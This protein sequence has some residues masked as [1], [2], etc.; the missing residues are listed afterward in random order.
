MTRAPALMVALAL[1]VRDPAPQ[2]PK[3]EQPH[4]YSIPLIDLAAE[5]GRRVV[6]DR[7][8]GWYRVRLMDNKHRRDCAYPG[9]VIQADG[10][11]VTTTYGHWSEGESPYVVSVR[12]KLAELDASAEGLGG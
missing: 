1:L 9:V 7:E 5:T 12:L 2:E 8:A 3:G 4:G 10:T 6:V 11:I